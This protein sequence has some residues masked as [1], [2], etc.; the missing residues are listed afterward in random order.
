MERINV[1]S[2]SSLAKTLGTI[3][4]ISGAF[5]VTLY[6]GPPILNTSSTVM[7][8]M[9]SQKQ[10]LSEQSNWVLGGVCV[11]ANCMLAASWLIVQASVLKKYRAEL[12]MV[13]NYCFF[14]AIQSVVVLQL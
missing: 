7:T 12:I 5:I 2:F 11:A 8:D 9:L 14:V 10:L 4:S 13:F 3:V 1:R 6:K